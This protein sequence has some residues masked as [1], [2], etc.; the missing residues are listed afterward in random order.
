MAFT[1]ITQIQSFESTDLFH[2]MQ[3]TYR[4]LRQNKHLIEESPNQAY[5][6]PLLFAPKS[7]WVRRNYQNR[8]PQWIRLR[9][10]LNNTWDACL[11]TLLG[12]STEVISLAFSSDGS[13]LASKSQDCTRLWETETGRC[14]GILPYSSKWGHLSFSPDDAVLVSGSDNGLKL[15][16]TATGSQRHLPV[17]RIF[18][19]RCLF[20][21][22]GQ[23]LAYSNYRCVELLDI[24]RRKNC[25]IFEFAK[26]DFRDMAFSHDSKR[27]I[28]ADSNDIEVWNLETSKIVATFREHYNRII[29]VQSSPDSHFVL[30]ASSESIWLWIQET[31]KRGKKLEGNI[32]GVIFANFSPDGRLIVSAH[33]MG[34]N[35]I[36]WE[37]ATGNKLHELTAPLPYLFKPMFSPDSTL[38]VIP[39][40]EGA[41]SWDTTTGKEI[42]TFETIEETNEKLAEISTC[43]K[44]GSIFAQTMGFKTIIWQV[45]TG[46]L[47]DT[48]VG[49]SD[50][51]SALEFSPAGNFIASASYDSTVKL[52]SFNRSTSKKATLRKEFAK[53]E[54]V[55]LSSD[56][57]LAASASNLGGIRLWNLESGSS[58]DLFGPNQSYHD[59]K[60]LAIS[61][62][63]SLL[64]GGKGSQIWIWETEKGSLRSEST[65]LSHYDNFHNWFNYDVHKIAFSSDSRVLKIA[66]RNGSI[67][68]MG[69][70]T[71]R[72]EHVEKPS[73]L[74]STQS[75]RSPNGRFTVKP[76]SGLGPFYLWEQQKIPKPA[77][78]KFALSGAGGF[79][80]F[81]QDSKL[82]AFVSSESIISIWET[83]TGA[84]RDVSSNFLHRPSVVSFSHDNRFL[85]Y[86]S[87]DENNLGILELSTGISWALG[88]ASPNPVR[89]VTFS[90][91]TSVVAAISGSAIVLSRIPSKS[92]AR[93]LEYDQKLVSDIT[94]LPDRNILIAGHEDGTIR[95]WDTNNYALLHT[96]ST[97]DRPPQFCLD[98]KRK[99]LW[100]GNRGFFF[101]E[102]LQLGKKSAIS[103]KDDWVLFNGERVFW[104]PAEFRPTN[105]WTWDASS[106][107][108]V[109][110]HPFGDLTLVHFDI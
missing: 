2:M 95:S 27:I 69:N 3:E 92:T 67:R 70:H 30:S 15:L 1:D 106:K 14:R 47:M 46:A 12:H 107:C 53:I 103:L 52:W 71:G 76:A 62:D 82:I 102:C 38:M 77:I 40:P 8:I 56:G 4:F 97:E 65:G 64:A 23:I 60:E 80:T 100:T 21:P 99:F 16:D 83:E 37:T 22:N 84:R 13:L 33:G 101:D 5:T 17:G 49:H 108:L 109:L 55:A 58:K 7:S 63:N 90:P 41:K 44:D 19:E 48:L 110:G 50:S 42:M 36:L 105:A 57:T 89:L 10:R 54:S 78:S 24:S 86:T 96:L 74:R 35:L 73:R 28:I 87:G 79:P 31:T 29:S 9:T 85:V 91:D 32:N 26:M 88:F 61:P 11:E 34:S 39:L 51:I 104:L 98:S 59:L 43:S 93:K 81:S 20:A 72:F 75:H 68:L 45:A 94:F 66:S 25:G 18:P 6:F